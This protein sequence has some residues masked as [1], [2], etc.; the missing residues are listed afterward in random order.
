MTEPVQDTVPQYRHQS[1][2]SALLVWVGV[3]AGIVF[4][5][6]VVFFSG[7]FIGRSTGDGFR[8]HH[9]RGGGGGYPGMMYPGMMGPGMGG[10]GMMGPNGPAQPGQRFPTTT[11]TAPPSPRP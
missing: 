3:T 9:G 5:V 7:F 8:F 6:A 10:P 2:A 1:R 11:T 4:I